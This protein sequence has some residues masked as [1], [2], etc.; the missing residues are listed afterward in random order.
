MSVAE[1][2]PA[3]KELPRLEKFQLLQF[4]VSEIGKEEG[5]SP[6]HPNISY[7]I[8]TP[9]NI[10]QETVTKLAAMLVDEVDNCER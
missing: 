1:L 4:L 9:Y 5:I 8:W 6:L 3:V 7:P 10:P 2:M